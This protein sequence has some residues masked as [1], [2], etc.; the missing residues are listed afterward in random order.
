MEQ[1]DTSNKASDQQ[2]AIDGTSDTADNASDA[3]RAIS[4]T[5]R[6]ASNAQLPQRKWW[7]LILLLVALIASSFCF[8]LIAG[9]TLVSSTLQSLVLAC[10]A[11]VAVLISDRHTLGLPR[12]STWS[13]SLWRWSIYL[14]VLALVG[15][16]VSVVFANGTGLDASAANAGSTAAEV[17]TGSLDAGTFVFRFL[18]VLVLCLFTGI[19][20]EGVFRTVSVDAFADALAPNRAPVLKAVILSAVL[21]G[22][23]HFSTGDIALAA[24]AEGAIGWAQLIL[25]P[26]EALLFGIVLAVVFVHTRNLWVVAGLHGVYDLLCM[27]PALI[28]TG[29]PETTYVTGSVFDLVVLVAT[30]ILLVPLV[31]F[32]LRSLV[33]HKSK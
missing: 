26:I 1:M 4:S 24:D 28:L 11:C 20:E 8:E 12:A 13:P 5:T 9:D 25:K 18:I 27:G 15:G 30:I 21:F 14:L 2:I 31:V 7:R 33:T 23:M 17:S 10:V 16:I 32:T 22:L 29:V 19:Y 3:D 6:A